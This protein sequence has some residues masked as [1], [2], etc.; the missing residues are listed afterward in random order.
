MSSA[1]RSLFLLGLLWMPV[2]LAGQERL[3]GI[4]AIVGD[5]VIL[6]SEVNQFAAQLAIQNRIDLRKHPEKFNELRKISRENLVIQKILLAKAREDT[7]TVDDARVDEEL[8]KQIQIWSQQL[9]SE[10]KIEEY[11]GIPVS[12]IKR[13]FREEVKN[14]LMVE[15]LQSQYVQK[16]TITRPEVERFY[17][18]MKDSLPEMKDMVKISHILRKIRAG[19]EGRDE[20]LKKIQDIRR[21]ILA[22]EDFSQ[23]ARQYSED[24]GSASRGGELGFISRGDFVKE[25]EEVAF[26]LQEGE[27]SEIV[28]TQFGF[29]LIQVVERRGEKINVRHI[30]IRLRPSEDDDR[31]TREF[32]STIRDSIILGSDFAEMA[33]KYSDDKTTADKGGNLG[34]FEVEQLQ[35]REFK[36]ALKGMEVG[37][38]SEPFR[39]E[40]GYHIIKLDDRREGGKLSLKR[41]WQQIEQMALARKR[42]KAMKKWVDELRKQV[43]VEIKE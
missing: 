3:D 21:R 22:G 11:F 9:G 15:T 31:Y 7:I 30:L 36:E 6:H 24:P 19:G 38:V 37:D 13:Q 5:E 20:A 41:D 34:W 29:H 17:E 28:E 33:R 25:F 16:I 35:V 26:H 40:F 14:R 2:L 4:A 8:D 43:Y 12:R 23:L 32:L 39:T 42:S 1:R 18:T 10:S 27:L